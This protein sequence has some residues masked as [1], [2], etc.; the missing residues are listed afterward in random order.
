M[1]L[2][3]HIIIHSFTV[4]FARMQFHSFT[5]MYLSM[6]GCQTGDIRLVNGRNGNEGR[7]EVCSNNAWGTVCDD[8]WGLNDAAVACR[9]L[10]FAAT[11]T[12]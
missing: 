9:Q 12:F 1:L 3:H 11:G 7:V 2:G 4:N 10:G 6:I 5:N 8:F